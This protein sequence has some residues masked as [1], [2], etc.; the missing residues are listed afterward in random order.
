MEQVIKDRPILLNRAPTLHRLGI[1]AFEPRLV[2]GKAIRLHPLVTNA[3]NADF[4]GDQMAIHV[5]I[6]KEAVGEAR[7]LMSGANAILGPKD[8]KAIV[9]PTQDMILGNYYV[10]LE[11]KGV[12]GEGMI[13]YNAQ[14]AIRTY[15]T[16]N[17]NLNALIG[18]AVKGLKVDKFP[19]G[20]EEKYVL[21]TVGRLI[22]NNV[23][24][25]TFP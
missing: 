6:T 2:K 16:G 24:Q 9:T 3:F 19:K 4:D 8:G 21:T 23:F 13:F 10:T 15:E 22:F 25:E 5:P 20:S 14:E 11:E 1:Q 12:Q 18:I 7:A 17:L